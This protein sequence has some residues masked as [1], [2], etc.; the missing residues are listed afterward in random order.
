MSKVFIRKYHPNYTIDQDS[1]IFEGPRRALKSLEEYIVENNHEKNHNYNEDCV[2]EIIAQ[3]V[4]ILYF[5]ASF[6][7]VVLGTRLKKPIRYYHLK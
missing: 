1:V 6:D 4:N 5:K 7:Y 3:G 2:Y